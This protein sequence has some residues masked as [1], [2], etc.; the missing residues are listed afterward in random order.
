DKLDYIWFHLWP[1][2]YKNE[3]T[4]YAKQI[5]RDKAE[6]KKRWK[7]MKDKG[8]IDSLAFIV[9]GERATTEPDKENID[10]IKV[11]LPKTLQPG[12]KT[13][14][15]TP[16]FVKIPTYS[17]RSGHLDQ[18]YMICQWYP[19]PAVYDKK[20]WHPMPYLDQGEFYS[21]FGSYDV[22]ITAPSSYVIGATGTLENEDELSAYK[23]IGT[24]NNDEKN[25]LKR[26]STRSPGK[27]KTLEYKGENIHDFAWFA[28][29][30]FIIR[31]DTA[32]LA[33]G[34]VIDVFTYS[35]ENGNANW[36][37]STSY[38]EDAIRNYSRWIGEY[39]YPVAQAV[40]GPKNVMSG[41]MEYPM[42]TL[43][44]S[45][46]ANEEHLDGVIA[47]E[48]G[49]NWFY[50]II[51][52]NERDHAWMDEGMNTYYQFRYEGEKYKANS[53]FGNALPQDVRN[54]PLPEF[55]AMIYG[56]LA[57]IPMDEAIETPSADFTDKDKYA[58][59]VYIKTSIWMYIIEVSIGTEKLDKVLKAYY[60][61]WK[62]RHPYPEDLKAEF[63]SQLGVKMDG[64]FEL[65]NKKGKF[66]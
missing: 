32:Q 64:I 58:M 23:Q 57:E 56:A 44:T 66:D 51:G 8:Y 55:F 7:D 46:D 2:A 59:V 37:K 60:D 19:K 52:S 34:K 10:I 21:E 24:N 38:V 6:G 45:P 41:G 33:S 36:I 35:Y 11:I 31:Y 29:K 20:G 47:H 27:T 22:K 12:E 14:I 62:F 3:S 61:K 17:S 4:A 40:E 54:K 9:N 28:D 1:N 30:D 25:T 43:I 48:V 13:T 53:V 5:F 15:T 26:Y 39:P 49:H 65:L 18:S 16:F 50:G 42:I 63:E